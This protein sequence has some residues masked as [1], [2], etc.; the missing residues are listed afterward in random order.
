MAQRQTED[1]IN[2]SIDKV[3]AFNEEFPEQVITQEGISARIA[4]R[5]MAPWQRVIKQTPEPA[6]LGVMKILRP[7]L[8]KGK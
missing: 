4:N 8:F 5:E 7:D 1:Q 3:L 6:R 2:A